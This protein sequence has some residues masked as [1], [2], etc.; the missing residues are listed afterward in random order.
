MRKILLV[1]A[2]AAALMIVPGAVPPAH[3]GGFGWLSV[4]A[5]FHIGPLSLALVFGRPFGSEGYYYRFPQPIAYRGIH[6]TSRCFVDH[7]VYYHDRAC[8]VVNAYFRAYRVDPYQVYVRYAPRIEGYGGGY[9]GPD[10]GY[11]DQGYYDQGYYDQGYYDQGYYD[12]GYYG[13]R[14]YY[15]GG[16][17]YYNRAP[18]RYRTYDRERHEG[19]NHYDRRDHGRNEHY[20]GGHRGHDR[21]GGHRDHGG[22]GGGNRH[23]GNHGHRH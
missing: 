15:G 13:G 12:Q 5:S 19:R 16:V 22:H 1:S 2:L 14:G 17:T 11:Y 6:C 20:D 7:G 9:Y 8:P 10:D 21:D 18:S 23:G 4:G 3:A